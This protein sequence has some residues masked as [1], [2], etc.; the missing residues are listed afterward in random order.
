MEMVEKEKYNFKYLA[1]PL[2]TNEKKNFNNFIKKRGLKMGFFVRQ[3]ILKALE[4]EK[5]E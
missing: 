3:L 5:Q 2:S 1:I 4:K